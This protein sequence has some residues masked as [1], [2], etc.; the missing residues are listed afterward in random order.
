MTDFYPFT[1]LEKKN[2]NYIIEITAKSSFNSNILNLESIKKE[3]QNI[4]KNFPNVQPIKQNKSTIFKIKTKYDLN[5][6][7]QKIKDALFVELTIPLAI[8]LCSKKEN[9]KNFLVNLNNSIITI[10]LEFVIDKKTFIVIRGPEKDVISAN[11]KISEFL[12]SLTNDIIQI[13]GEEIDKKKPIKEKVDFYEIINN[14][15]KKECNFQNLKNYT[16]IKLGDLENNSTLETSL[17][18]QSSDKLQKFN[19][20]FFFSPFACNT[21]VPSRMNSFEGYYKGMCFFMENPLILD[22]NF[23]SKKI[24][25]L[26][27]Y[28]KEKLENILF[29]NNTYLETTE[30]N[31]PKIIGRSIRDIKNTVMLLQQLDQQILILEMIIGNNQIFEDRCIVLKPRNDSN[32]KSLL[33][34]HKCNLMNTIKEEG[35]DLKIFMTIDLNSEEFVCGK[36]NG[37]INKIAVENDVNIS[38]LKQQSSLI[39]TISGKSSNVIVAH[40]QIEDEYPE[41]LTFDLDEKYHKRIIGVGGKTI[42][43]IMK[44]HGVYIKFMTR[45]EQKKLNFPGNAIIKTPRKNKNSLILMKNEVLELAGIFDKEIVEQKFLINYLEFYATKS[46]FKFCEKNIQIQK[47]GIISSQ[48]IYFN[49]SHSPSSVLIKIKENNIYGDTSEKKDDLKSSDWTTQEISHFSFF[50]KIS[51]EKP[52]FFDKYFKDNW[53]KF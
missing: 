24:F 27:Y 41:E 40:T 26:E 46:L 1:S 19:E 33:I 3:L 42:Q 50:K 13:A 48:K 8:F 25:F 53:N 5:K 28:Q 38:F 18:E 22:Y 36:K 11:L 14:E 31:R 43:K 2:D 51:T 49:K 15:K 17:R 39:I 34:I 20:P 29:E 44:K 6:T 12:E 4:Q 35:A 47:D 21:Y 37:K 32:S 16:T 45:F 52:V 23:C 7:L 30:L 10:I 9:I